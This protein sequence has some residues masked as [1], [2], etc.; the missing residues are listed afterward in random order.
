MN[1]V[2][3]TVAAVAVAVLLP[4]LAFG[5]IPQF[6]GR[7]VLVAIV[8]GATALFAL[9]VPPG[10]GYLIYPRDGWKC[11]G[12]YAIPHLAKL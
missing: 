4:L 7:I 5:P 12:L 11:A 8:G 1:P 9:I 3:S 6:F 10:T 2:F